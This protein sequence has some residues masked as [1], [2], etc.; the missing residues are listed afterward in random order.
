LDAG[1]TLRY[2]SDRVGFSAGAA[3]LP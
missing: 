2:L 3:L 1:A